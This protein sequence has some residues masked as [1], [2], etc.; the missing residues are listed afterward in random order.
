[1]GFVF[2]LGIRSCFLSRRE[3]PLHG[4]GGNTGSDGIP[5][6][7]PCPK[8][9]L[10]RDGLLLSDSAYRLLG[11]DNDRIQTQCCKDSVISCVKSIH[12]RA[13]RRNILKVF[14]DEYDPDH[15]GFKS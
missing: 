10:G 8:I 14:V 4:K 12:P 13:L 11:G 7:L 3:L 2:K 15:S 5:A 6:L 9:G 1:M